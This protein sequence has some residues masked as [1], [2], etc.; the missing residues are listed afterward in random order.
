[1]GSVLTRLRLRDFELL[2]AI[3]EHKS[4]TSAALQLGFTQP[5]ASR[6]LKDM[7]Q[8]LRAHLFEPRSRKDRLLDCSRTCGC[9]S[10]MR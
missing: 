5:A 3:D 9:R 7:E 2:V 4:I 8:L 6:A 10:S 1:M